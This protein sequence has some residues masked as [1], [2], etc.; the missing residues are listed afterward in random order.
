MKNIINQII[1]EIAN[2][3]F[4]EYE[5]K[6]KKVSSGGVKFSINFP[7]IIINGGFAYR[8]NTSNEIEYFSYPTIEIK[9]SEVENVRT[10]IL[11]KYSISDETFP[12]ILF[13]DNEWRE[14]Y[15]WQKF[16]LDNITS[17]QAHTVKILERFET[18]MLPMAEQYLSLPYWAQHYEKKKANLYQNNEPDSFYRLVNDN[19]SL[20]HLIILKLCGSP[21]FEEAYIEQIKPSIEYL[22]SQSD[23]DSKDYKSVQQYKQ[24]LLDLKETLDATPAKYDYRDI[25]PPY[26]FIKKVDAKP[27]EPKPSASEVYLEDRAVNVEIN[28]FEISAE[29]QAKIDSFLK[30][31]KKHFEAIREVIIDNAE[32]ENEQGQLQN[33]EDCSYV[34][35]DIAEAKGLLD[36][37]KLGFE[38]AAAQYLYLKEI[39][40]DP[41]QNQVTCTV[42]SDFSNKQL[43]A[44]L[45]LDGN[46]EIVYM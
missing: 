30:E 1:F 10:P 27:V 32:F 12:S 8:F 5:I 35:Q 2:V 37:Q 17:I 44:L 22:E 20:K 45:G 46:V 34:I 39:A 40:I 16:K 25:T 38:R 42:A 33:F 11:N 23:K 15:V 36:G 26:R 24:I 3:F 41:D 31:I 43:T 13:I 18:Y 6:V 7:D 4:K 19:Y 29:Q 14:K 21:S 28:A 9:F